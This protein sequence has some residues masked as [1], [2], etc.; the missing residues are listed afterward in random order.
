MMRIA[1]IV[2]A[3]PTL[4]ETFILNQ[5]TGL[6]DRGHVVDIYASQ[7]GDLSKVHKAVI[8]Y[9]LLEKTRYIPQI[10][11]NYFRRLIKAIGLVLLNFYKKPVVFFNSINVFKYGK[12]ATSLRSLYRI[13][14][15]LNAPSYD[16]IQC[17]FGPAGLLGIRLR[18][19]GALQGKVITTFHGYDISKSLHL[20]GNRYKELFEKGDLF[21]P[22]SKTW[23][24]KLISLGCPEN[25]TLVHHMG[26]KPESFATKHR[27][28]NHSK[29][30]T[31]LS[32]ARLSE[33]KGLEYGIRAIAHLKDKGVNV[34][35]RI[36]GEGPLRDDLEALVKE[37]S[38]QDVVELQGSKNTEDIKYLLEEA[39]IFSAPSVTASNGSQEGIPVAIMEAMA[40]GLPVVS[41]IHSGIPE[42]VKDG[43]SGF[44]VPERD[45][46]ALAER[47]GFL[48]E[49]S[50]LWPKFGKAGRKYVEENFN[51]DRLNDQ[52][53][54]I[55][56]G[57]WNN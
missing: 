28:M 36:I 1:F 6:I 26:I 15:F 25:K 19:L 39:D 9:E 10:P 44:L 11:K 51:I 55:Y 22:I 20:Q 37:L 23:K 24:K 8:K 32:I 52:L 30:V 50:E 12:K 14:P 13:I 38:L 42:L 21:L 17:H 45:V 3:F 35:Y 53:V 43:I 31:I 4:S 2:G 33:K 49:H 7:R 34:I 18:E 16:I 54:K 57:V 41:T 27:Q 40:T 48:I 29:R 5:I 47:L 56:Q 46:G